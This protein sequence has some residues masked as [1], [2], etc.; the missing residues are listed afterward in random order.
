MKTPKCQYRLLCWW[1]LILLTPAGFPQGG[2][3][4]PDAAGRESSGQQIYRI[5]ESL[6][7]AYEK[8]APLAFIK[9]FPG[10]LQRYVQIT[11]QRSNLMDFAAMSALTAL[12]VAAD[13]PML[14]ETQRFG[15]RIGLTGNNK[16]KRA[17]YVFGLPIEV[18]RDA[19]TWMY[20]IGDGLTHTGIAAA[21]LSYGLIAGNN[22]ALQTASQLAEGMIATGFSTQFLK[23]ITGRESPFVATVDGGRWRPFPNQVEYHQHVPHYDAYPSGHLATA[24]MTVTVIAENY[25]GNKLIRPLGYALMTVLSFEMV[26]NGV[27]WVSDYPLALMMGYTFGKIAVARGRKELSPDYDA[28]SPVP[29][30]VSLVPYFNGRMIG[31][32]LAF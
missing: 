9:H 21:F 22:R 29:D 26:N 13:Q 6:S 1:V 23:H 18:P 7:Y 20:F 30:R 24:M 15:R 8:P 19:D 14:D 17:F 2:D 3:T 16:M 28:K 12:M 25:P 10:N 27:H 4:S 31:A 32:R 5:N 11:F